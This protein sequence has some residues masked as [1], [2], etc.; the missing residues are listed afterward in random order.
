MVQ[1]SGAMV[2]WRID[3]PV[4]LSDR[5]GGPSHGAPPSRRT[6]VPSHRSNQFVPVTALGRG[7]LS[8][9]PIAVARNPSL[10]KMR[11]AG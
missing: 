9:N 1:G 3:A 8:C 10:T 7:G 5:R 11:A 2:R 4:A 6:A